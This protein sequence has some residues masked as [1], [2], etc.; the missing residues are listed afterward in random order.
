MQIR[1]A[2][3]RAVLGVNKEQII[4]FW[5]IGKVIAANTKYGNKFI[6]NLARDISEEFPD[7][8]GFSAR[9]LKYMHKF[10]E[11]Y[12]DS[13]KVP[14]VLAL[15]SWSHNRLLLDKVKDP[16]EAF[17]YAEKTVQNGWS[18]SILE[19]QIETKL[20]ERQAMADKTTNYS[21]MLPH[22]QSGLAQETIKSPYVFDFI[23]KRN[24]II[25]REI[26]NEMVASIAKTLLE[27]GRGFAFVGNQYHLEVGGNDYYLD[28]LF[29]N[30]EL[31]CYFVIEIKAGKFIP[32]FAGKLNFYLSVVDDT[33]RH[34]TDNP[35]IGILLCK[36]K[37][38]LIAE[39]A[40]KDMTKPIGVSEYKLS[41]Y[42]PEELADT[43]PSVED[44]ER[45]I[46]MRMDINEGG[47]R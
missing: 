22:P 9:N 39:Y 44:I 13:Q 32:E 25:E 3:Y 43:L 41:D 19:H 14:T 35:S 15:L 1:E 16:D 46:R 18:L 33:L 29:Y 28:L 30:T 11:V 23:E 17:W 40:L 34:E 6:E 8:K 38:K 37:N 26:E 45:R 5:S 36:E 10:A 2:Q 42:V 31:R 20:Y 4:L 12:G 27:L 7:T 21:D 47:E 24:G